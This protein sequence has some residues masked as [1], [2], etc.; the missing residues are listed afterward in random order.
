MKPQFNTG[1]ALCVIGKL[2]K[3]RRGGRR[4]RSGF[5]VKRAGEFGEELSFERRRKDHRPTTTTII[6]IISITVAFGSVKTIPICHIVV[7]PF[8]KEGVRK[9]RTNASC[10][11]IVFVFS[12]VC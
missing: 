3:R 4:R 1:A 11:P 8:E 7:V 2:R 5:V 6:M 9:G 10:L 12:I